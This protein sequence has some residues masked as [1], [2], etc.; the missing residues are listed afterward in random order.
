VARVSSYLAQLDEGEWGKV[1]AYA[2]R[3]KV[4]RRARGL[5][6]SGQ[7]EN[8]HT[9]LAELELTDGFADAHRCL[10]ERVISAQLDRLCALARA[11]GPATPQALA[12]FLAGMRD[13]NVARSGETFSARVSYPTVQTGSLH[14]TR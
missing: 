7:H 5:A 3:A 10:T 12:L 6:R 11:S 4:L 2:H 13:S 8:H 1:K 9:I 14:R